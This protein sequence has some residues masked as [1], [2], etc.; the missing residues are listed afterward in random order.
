LQLK[1]IKTKI[2]NYFASFSKLN[3]TY[4]AVI[5][6]SLF[7]ITALIGILNHEMWLDEYQAWLVSR[8]C[9][10]LANLWNDLKF[11]GHLITY[12][13]IL[14]YI[15]SIIDNPASIQ[16]LN[17]L[18]GT[19]SIYILTKYS[20]FSKIQ[21]I[22]ISFGY[23]FLFEYTI[24]SRPYVM[25]MFF[26]LLTC[27]TF[28]NFSK[29]KLLFSI[30]L[31][32]LANTHIY[33]TIIAC[34]FGLM[35]LWMLW[36]KEKSTNLKS[37]LSSWSLP[38]G[39]IA[40]GISFAFFQIYRT[41]TTNYAKRFYWQGGF[42]Y[43][44]VSEVASNFL[45]GYFPIPPI[46]K[47][48]FWNET[49]ISNL[50]GTLSIILTVI[51]ILLFLIYFSNKKPASFLYIF[52]SISILYFFYINEK[53]PAIRFS[54]HL[55]LILIAAYWVYLELPVDTTFNKFINKAQKAL[56]ILPKSFF[57]IIL[58]IQL[59]ASC[60]AYENGLTYPFS[61]TK[62]AGEF[63]QKNNLLDLTM[64]GANSC[65]VSPLTAITG[66]PINLMNRNTSDYYLVFDDNF[67]ETPPANKV[68]DRAFELT[69]QHDSLLLILSVKLNDLDTDNTHI[70]YFN[71]FNKHITSAY[72]LGKC[73]DK[74]IIGEKFYFF[75]LNK[76]H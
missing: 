30:S 71:Y 13:I 10:S 37:I 28:K 67:Q 40:T 12:H 69:M 31:V 18:F 72:Y 60:I 51:I 74:S 3:N 43:N 6:T 52:G 9:G 2:L 64:F 61:N 58:I 32:L 54:G 4:F 47:I 65:V 24:I 39:I 70:M 41:S 29:K 49:I 55:Y 56:G 26:L 36:R 46:N 19:G 20:P 57:I 25:V 33:G 66:K 50:P 63:I 76:L 75:K 45:S 27:Y 53:P 5:I 35:F 42:D 8:Y 21:N 1:N 68:L 59:F 16:Y 11:E 7:F 14:Y 34:S 48:Q 62:T 38:L 23:F 44:R 15:S 17:L 22:L 73:E